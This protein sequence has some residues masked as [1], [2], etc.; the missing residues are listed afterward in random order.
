MGKAKGDRGMQLLDATPKAQASQG[1]D[2]PVL[3]HGA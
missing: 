2:V 1:L 3:L